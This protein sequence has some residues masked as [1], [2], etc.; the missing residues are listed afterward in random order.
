MA[1]QGLHQ[2]SLAS[3]WVLGA[4]VVGALV[5]PWQKLFARDE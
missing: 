2:P 1:A 3:P 4:E 5:V